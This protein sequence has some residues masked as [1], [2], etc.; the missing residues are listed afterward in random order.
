MEH[1]KCYYCKDC[2]KF[3]NFNN[4]YVYKCKVGICKKRKGTLP[5]GVKK[6]IFY[7]NI[8]NGSH[9]TP[10][11]IAW[12]TTIKEFFKKTIREGKL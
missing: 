10:T 9:I 8:R 2:E 1:I 5:P 6:R 12:K 4:R 3:L 11:S 7:K